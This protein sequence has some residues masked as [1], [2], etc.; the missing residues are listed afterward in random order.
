MSKAA[1][2]A[3]IGVSLSTSRKSVEKLQSSSQ[4]KAKSEPS[5]R[6][7]SLR[8][9]I[10]REDVLREALRRSR[11]N[12]GSPGVDGIDFAAIEASGMDE[13]LGTLQEELRSKRYAPHHFFVYESQS[14]M[15]AN[16][17]RPLSIPTVKDRVVQTALV[18]VL[19][20]IFE[21]DLAPQ[22]Y[23]FRPVMDAKMAVRRVYFHITQYDRQEVV[24]AD[25]SDYFTTIPHGPLLRCVSRRV[26]DRA[27][28]SVIKRWLTV[29]VWERTA[30]GAVLCSTQALDRKR[31]TPQGGTASPLLANLYFRRFLR[32]WYEHG[33]SRRLDAHVVNYADDLVI[34]CP[35]GNGSAALAIMRQLMEPLGLT[36]NDHKTRIARLPEEA[37]DFLGYTVGRFY[38]KDGRAFIGTEPSRKSV[39]RVVEKIHDETTSR[40]NRD[41]AETRVEELNA[42]LRGWSGYFN[43][44]RVIGAYRVIREYTESRLRRWLIRRQGKRGTGYRQYPNEY[45]Y[46]GSRRPS[47]RGCSRWLPP[48]QSH[49]EL[50]RVVASTIASVLRQSAS[51]VAGGV[52]IDFANRESAPEPG[53]RSHTVLRS[54]AAPLQLA[55]CCGSH[56][57][58]GTCV[59]REPNSPPR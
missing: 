19:G 27:I 32:A 41:S 53:F 36:V 35:S 40:W 57:N 47:V 17:Q 59:S 16:G 8:D 56:T 11:A 52:G 20:P 50:G 14:E 58:R 22:Q 24:D 31:G 10:C 45:P 37:F 7:Y 49:L 13:W 43:Q 23:G 30:R 25:L 55:H 21:A 9:K 1:T 48:S 2:A 39:R 38:G 5:Y 44:G 29:S 46:K 15:V 26:A 33:H 3:E 12:A 18:L 28:L 51:N 42:L 34:C 54:S 4:A 6:F